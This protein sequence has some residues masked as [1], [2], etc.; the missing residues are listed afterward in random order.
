MNFLILKPKID[1]KKDID[2]KNFSK[3]NLK[4]FS[5]NYINSI[6]LNYGS[7]KKKLG[8]M[9]NVTIKKNKYIKNRK[10]LIKSANNFF[11]NIGSEWK[12]DYLAIN[13]DVGSFLGFKMKSGIIDLNGSCNNFLGCQMRGGKIFVKNN[14]GDY[15]GSA[16]Y[17]EKIGM[18]GGV[19]CI[20]G[21]AKNYLGQY[22]RRGLI[23]VRKNVGD[24]C[25]NNLI[26]GTI[27]IHRKINNS[28]CIG[29][30]RGTII[31]SKKPKKID[32]SFVMCGVQEINFFSIL[33][34][35]LIKEKIYKKLNF[36]VFEKYIGN[37]INFGLGELLIRK[38]N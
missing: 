5:L 3:V 21:N 10:V 35:Y 33:S 8:S 15:A 20:N 7:R 17:G 11:Q 9:F 36:S 23:I 24:F 2:F 22:M 18:N 26:A 27:I 25:A 13:G 28:F 32:E 34:N 19:I 38:K 29:M 16:I 37:R 1:I 6:E 12:D 30:K 14:V 4:P 31:L